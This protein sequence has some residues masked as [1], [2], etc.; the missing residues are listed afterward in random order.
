VGK[1][2]QVLEWQIDRALLQSHH[3][4]KGHLHERD[5]IEVVDVTLCS[6]PDEGSQ[7]LSA[8]EGVATLPI[9]VR[10]EEI[11]ENSSLLRLCGKLLIRHLHKVDVVVSGDIESESD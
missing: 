2:S 7:A 5:E 8:L 10:V 9:D 11:K 3:G 4:D 1:I 6:L